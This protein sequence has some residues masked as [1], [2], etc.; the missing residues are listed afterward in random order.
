VL[1]CA[2]FLEPGR[3]FDRE[4]RAELA[5]RFPDN[6]QAVVLEVARRRILYAITT[7]W[8]LPEPTVRFWNSIAD[9]ASSR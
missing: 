1:Y 8:S 7:G 3:S 9:S 5:R 6:P 4:E 2:D